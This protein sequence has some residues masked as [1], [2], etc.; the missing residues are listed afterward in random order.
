MEDGARQ[1][2]SCSA[3][4][5][6]AEKCTALNTPLH[7]YF[8][9]VRRPLAFGRFPGLPGYTAYLAPPIS[10]RDEEGLS[11]CLARLCHHAVDNHPAGVAHR[12]SPFAMIPVAFAKTLPARPPGLKVSRPPLVR[13][14]YGLVTRSHP[15]DGSSVGFRVPVSQLQPCYPSYGAP[16]LTP[17]GLTP[18]G[19]ASLRW[20]HSAVPWNQSFRMWGYER[21]NGCSWPVSD[22]RATVA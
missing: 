20:T 11:S 21:T 9:P 17:V 18:T 15:Y 7:R 4:S 1:I 12:I 6:S 16:T 19:R 13:L 2:I 14:R 8:G 5:H 22:L 10:R 3:S